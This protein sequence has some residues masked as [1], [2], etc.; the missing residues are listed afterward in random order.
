MSEKQKWRRWITLIDRD[1]FDSIREDKLIFDSYYELIESNKEI[2]SPWNFHQWVLRNHGH[3][4]MLHVR[5][6]SDEDSRTYSLRKL[7]GAISQNPQLITKRS[8]LSAYRPHHRDIAVNN[9]AKYTGNA[10]A[11]SLPKAVPLKDIELLK[12]L[13]T[14]ICNLVNKEIAHLDRRRRRR[15]TNFDELYV[16]L[17]KLVT[18]TA[19]YGDLLGRPVADDLDNFA[20]TYDWMSIFDVP[21]RGRASSP[22]FNPDAASTDK[23]LPHSS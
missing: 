14:R 16:L 21:W 11:K 15:V 22:L 9:W 5:K 20:I 1:V 12:R 23:R 8:F 7:I 13:S 6:L 19:K 2:V 3:T 18:L 4:L 17:R 10:N